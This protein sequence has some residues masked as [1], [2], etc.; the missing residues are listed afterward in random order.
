METIGC[1]M[2]R[3][4]RMTRRVEIC[5]VLR[6]LPGV[7]REL[8][9]TART[10]GAQEAKAIGLVTEVYPDLQALHAEVDRVA[11]AKSPIAVTGTKS[12][13]LKCRWASQ[14]C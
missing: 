1:S 13:M 2:C 14:K 8:A 12:V 3:S 5:L 6:L 11:A 4:W 7:A 10:I 9:L